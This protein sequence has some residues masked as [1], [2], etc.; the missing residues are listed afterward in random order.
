[1]G[2]GNVGSPR[3]IFKRRFRWTLEISTPCGFIP[4]HYVKVAARPKL[5]V[6]PT[7]INYLNATTWIPGKAKWDPISVKYIDVANNDMQGLWNWFATI[8]NFQDDNNLSMSEKAGWY[9]IGNLILYDGCGAPLERWLLKSMF[10]ESIDF[11][12]L[13]YSNSEELTIDLSL[14]YSEVKY[15]GLCGP[16]P[17]ACCEGCN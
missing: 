12:E 1:M 13:D 16:T 6:E 17:Q 2:I 15:Q 8:Y 14:R 11:G 9:G 10:P 7:E 5:T 4:K 3:V